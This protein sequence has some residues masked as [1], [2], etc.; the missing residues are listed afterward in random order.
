MAIVHNERVMSPRLAARIAS[1]R[2]ELARLHA[3]GVDPI[4]ELHDFVRDR[5]EFEPLLE[6]YQEYLR[7]ETTPDEE[8]DRLDAR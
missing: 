2:D 3:Q 8:H 7:G 5:F 6:A 4:E 1:L